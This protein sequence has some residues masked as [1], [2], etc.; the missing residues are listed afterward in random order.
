MN[1]LT[2]Y[3]CYGGW[4]FSP[5]EYVNNSWYTWAGQLGVFLVSDLDKVLY[6]V[7]GITLIM[8]AITLW[9]LLVTHLV[10]VTFLF[11]NFIANYVIQNSFP[12]IYFSVL[13][14]VPFTGHAMLTLIVIL[15]N[16][17]PKARTEKAANVT[18]T[19][20]GSGRNDT[21]KITRIE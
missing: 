6:G 3:I 5:Q 16:I 20:F 15:F 21:T 7:F 2:G 10:T 1:P 14:I 19:N 18:V 11:G 9:R 12:I 8:D 13:E 4:W 17:P